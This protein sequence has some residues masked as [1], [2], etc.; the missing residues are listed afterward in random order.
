MWLSN[1]H[2][3]SAM[4]LC[5]PPI[6][7]GVCGAWKGLM[8]TVIMAVNPQAW[9]HLKSP[10]TFDSWSLFITFST[11]ILKTFREG[12]DMNA[13]FGD[14]HSEIFWSLHIGQSGV[15][16]VAIVIDIWL[17][18]GHV[19]VQFFFHNLF[20]LHRCWSFLLISCISVSTST[21]EI[22]STLDCHVCDGIPEFPQHWVVTLKYFVL[23]SY[24]F[25][26]E[27]STWQLSLCCCWQ[28]CECVAVKDAHVPSWEPNGQK[29]V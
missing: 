8:S 25:R 5:V 15:G 26:I 20:P 19:T 13:Q 1:A 4:V 11:S 22:D 29:C 7:A 14:E 12:C 2:S 18:R 10:I 9:L 6:Y 21:K 16:F 27:C 23:L 28:P 17:F 24:V 3:S